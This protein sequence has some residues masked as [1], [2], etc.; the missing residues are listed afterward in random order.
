MKETNLSPALAGAIEKMN[1][2]FGGELFTVGKHNKKGDRIRFSSPLLNY[3][4]YGGIPLG[5]NVEFFGEEN[6]GKTSL[7]G[8]IIKNVQ[9]YAKKEYQDKVTDLTSE[10]DELRIKNNKSD[11]KKIA[12]LEAELEEVQARGARKVIYYDIEGTLDTVYFKTQLG[13]DTDDMLVFTPTVQTAEEILQTVLD[14]TVTGDVIALVLDSVPALVP[15]QVMDKK[16]KEKSM[17]VLAQV[18][19]DFLPKVTPLLHQNKALLLSIN[20]LR[21]NFQNP[22]DRFKTVGG[23]SWKFGQSL[24]LTLFKDKCYNNKYADIPDKDGNPYGHS[25]LVHCKKTKI[26]NP[27]RKRVTIGYT[28]GKGF[29]SVLDLIHLGLECDFIVQTGSWYTI[30]NKGL[31]PMYY[32]AALCKFQGLGNL[33]EFLENHLDIYKEIEESIYEKVI[34]PEIDIDIDE[35]THE[36]QGEQSNLEG[37]GA[38]VTEKSDVSAEEYLAKMKE[39]GFM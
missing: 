15:Q 28:Y 19:T 24:R 20:Q 30:Y 11:Q 29:D 17:G 31:E 2:D 26:C 4:T 35:D 10:L 23:R 34:P 27:D 38:E 36:E 39:E 33:Y 12:K 13:V 6:A 9:V 25:V 37:Q 1:K 18:L 5:I 21:D 8:D 32:E 3:M 7:C 14:L 16:L 22:Y